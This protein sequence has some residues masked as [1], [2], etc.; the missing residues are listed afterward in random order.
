MTALAGDYYEAYRAQIIE[1]S[2]LDAAV[3]HLAGRTES[4]GGIY[5]PLGDLLRGKNGELQNV[6]GRRLIGCNPSATVARIIPEEPYGAKDFKLE[7]TLRC[8]D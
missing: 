7:M 6:Y 2:G 1:Q 4:S 5:L 3:S 8:S